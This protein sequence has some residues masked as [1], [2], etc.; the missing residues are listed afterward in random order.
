MKFRNLLFSVALFTIGILSAQ[1]NCSKY[2]PLEEGASFQYTMYDKKGKADGT[3]EYKITDVSNSGGD[4]N[5][6]MH[7]EFMDKKGKE[8]FTSDYTFTCTGNG[9]KIDYNSIMPQSMLEQFKDMEY[10]ITGTDIE[11]PNDLSV[12]QSLNDA[13]VSMSISMAGMKMD[14]EVNMVE[15]KVEKKESITTPAGTFDCFVISEVTESKTMGAT[16]SFPSRLW[17]AEG[18]GM[19]KQETYKKGGSLMSSVELTKLDK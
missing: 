17:L 7:M 13:N 2:Y 9:I 11:L 14:M 8:V 19:V 16:Q 1:D 18:I 15:R 10:D 12:G 5:A 6:T 3:T 4:T